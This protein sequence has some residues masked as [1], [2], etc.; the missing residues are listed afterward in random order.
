MIFDMHSH[1]P[2]RFYIICYKIQLFVYKKQ[3]NFYFNLIH[4]SFYR[5]LRHRFKMAE[6]EK[7]IH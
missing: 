3:V 2:A 1:E 6:T 7:F 5:N 4:N